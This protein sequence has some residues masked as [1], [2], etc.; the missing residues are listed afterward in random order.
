MSETT[1]RSAEI[2]AALLPAYKNASKLKLKAKQIKALTKPFPDK[3][4]EI[5]ETGSCFIPHILVSQ[6]LNEVFGICGWSLICRD[7][8]IQ[9]E[10]DALYAEM[11]LVV[12]SCFVDEDAVEVQTDPLKKTSYFD[13]LEFAKGKA[14]R[15]IC[16]KRL[17]CGNQVWNPNYCQTWQDKFAEEFSREDGSTG[18]RKKGAKVRISDF[19]ETPVTAKT[20]KPK[21][22]ENLRHVMLQILQTQGNP[23]VLAYAIANGILKEGQTL[24]EWPLHAVA[25]GEREIRQLQIKI[26]EHFAKPVEAGDWKRFEIPFGGMKGQKLG[27]LSKENAAGYWEVVCEDASAI[28]KKYPEFKN[29]LDE[30]GKLFNFT[31]LKKTK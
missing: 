2:S 21:A 17:S 3:D 15:A 7:H 31:R 27:E 16:G 12:N 1:N 25:V 26:Q 30:A 9:E 24:D 5:L 6:R 4:V 18:W 13:A 23:N 28:G 29:A 22:D 11:V 10:N 20:S 14:L 8:Y 19:T